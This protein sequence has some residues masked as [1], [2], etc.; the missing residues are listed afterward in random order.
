MREF[1]SSLPGPVRVGIEATESWMQWFEYLMGGSS[2]DLN[3]LGGHPARFGRP[4]RGSR[5]MMARSELILKLL[6]ENSF[7]AISLPSKELQDMQSLL[8]H[9][10]QSVRMRTRIQNAFASIALANGLPRSTALWSQVGQSRM[11]V[12]V[13]SPYRLWGR[14]RVNIL[15]EGGSGSV[16]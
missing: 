2:R 8:R 13:R 6:A 3:A 1:Y 11:R 15:V 10:H 16:G 5:K 14:V 4:R 12:V 9:R 7:A